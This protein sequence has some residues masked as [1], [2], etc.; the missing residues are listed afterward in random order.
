MKVPEPPKPVRLDHISPSIYEVS[1][2]CLAK[3]VWY[4]QGD[5]RTLPDHP[6]AILGVCFHTVVAASHYGNLRG[7]GKSV[8]ENAR[9]LFDKQANSLYEGVHPLMKA[10]FSIPERLP[11]YNLYRERAALYAEQAAES[12]PT[13]SVDSSRG[14]SGSLLKQHTEMRLE[15]ADGLI[16]GR[17][18]Q[19]D[20]Y[21]DTVVDYK[22][23]IA[24]G[25]KPDAVSEAEARQLRLY[26]YLACE[27]DIP[28][29]KGA[30]VR[31]NGRRIEIG[32]TRSDADAEASNA[33]RQLQAINEAIAAGQHF[34]DLASPS[35]ENCQMCTCLPFCEAFWRDSKTEWAE[36][37]GVHVEGLVREVNT[38]TT[39]GV[40]LVTL[41]IEPQRG[42]LNGV[43]AFIEQIP[44]SWLTIEGTLPQVGDVI[45]VV[46]ARQSNIE[47]DVAVLR[48]DKALTSLWTA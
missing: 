36:H 29:S 28:I 20:D 12:R 48:V 11:Y 16:V 9:N 32:V 40:V 17:P 26:A 34:D 37:C 5:R 8:R 21:S 39:Q 10:K 33:R 18:D 45:R 1:L 44:K 42:T 22:S 27:R 30:I 6:A 3:A 35:P 13:S 14:A 15:S 24:M 46:H 25:D 7:D 19:I 23:G 41:S 31:G 47:G 38:T 4:A 2:N 43:S